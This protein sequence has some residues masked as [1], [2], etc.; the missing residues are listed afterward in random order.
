MDTHELLAQ[1]DPARIAQR[2][3]VIE[4]ERAALLVLLRAARARRRAALSH[5]RPDTAVSDR[6]PEAAPC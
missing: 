5:R 6:H 3:D 1:L 4:Q 2:I